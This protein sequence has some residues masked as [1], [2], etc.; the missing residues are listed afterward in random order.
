[1]LV[2]LDGHS[3]ADVSTEAIS[4]TVFQRWY[5]V[6]MG[7]G[8]DQIVVPTDASQ[9]VRTQQ[10]LD[11]AVTMVGEVT[12]AKVPSI[13]ETG[14]AIRIDQMNLRNPDDDEVEI[15]RQFTG[16]VNIPVGTSFPSNSQLTCTGYLSRLR[17]VVLADHD[18]TGMTDNEAA[19]YILDICNVPFDSAD[20]H[21]WGY[22]LGQVKPVIWTAGT[23]GA[24]VLTDMD[25]VFNC[26]T[27]EL[28]SGRVFRIP[29]N[30]APYQYDSP[31]FAEAFRKGSPGH[32]FYSNERTRGDIDQVQNYWEVQ[33]LSWEGAEGAADEGVRYQVYARAYADHAIL[34]PSIYI[35]VGQPFTS[36]LIQTE[37]VAK[38]IAIRL[39]QETNREPDTIRIDSANQYRIVPGALILVKDQTPDVDLQSDKRYLVTSVTR[40]TDFMSIEGV[41]GP[42]GATGTV[43]SG[44]WKETPDATTD[45]GTDPGAFDPGLPDLPPFDDP[46]FEIPEFPDPGEITIPDTTDPL[47]CDT[48]TPPGDLRG[49][50]ELPDGLQAPWRI[51]GNGTWHW[52]LDGRDI[53]AFWSTAA[54]NFLYYNLTE[55]YASK[56]AV[57]DENV[58]GAGATFS[59]GG[60]VQFC[61]DH[62]VLRINLAAV[63]GVGSFI[64]IAWVE[65]YTDPGFAHAGDHFG[66][67]AATEN[68]GG[69]AEGGAAPHEEI[70]FGNRNNGGIAGSPGAVGE[71][72]SWAVSFDL[73]AERQKVFFSG[74]FGSGYIH[75][76]YWASPPVGPAPGTV[77]TYTP[78][79]HTKHVLEIT[80]SAGSTGTT[81]CPAIR[82]ILQ[83]MGTDCNP[84]PDYPLD[85]E[86][87]TDDWMDEP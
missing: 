67:F 33:G 50:Y 23:S 56:S 49:I 45:V 6:L 64:D 13:L 16:T 63:D 22:E 10:S 17:R 61:D 2:G 84:N 58:A 47:L 71:V 24:S 42:T 83:D 4:M 39:M 75:D 73:S 29:Y 3:D 51:L 54:S 65:F 1:M 32:A 25:R 48:T 19:E 68:L 77:A 36:D 5:R 34:D 41:G 59:V 40:E 18:L 21:G 14:V 12:L 79:T 28:G 27:M 70:Y 87:G 15:N 62:G 72:L 82:L 7:S 37:D 76:F 26:S 43:S 35:G 74:D 11:S 81:D 38:A 31:T 55:P 52:D 8:D 86:P 80:Y 53:V 46:G 66:V 60:T 20:I 78:C 85:P 44:I 30:R 9:A 57:N 69:V